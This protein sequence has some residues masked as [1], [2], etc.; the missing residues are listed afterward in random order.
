MFPEYFESP[1]SERYTDMPVKSDYTGARCI[2]YIPI[3]Q[4][5][6]VGEI[7]DISSEIHVTND[8]LRA[9]G[10]ALALTTTVLL[11]DTANHDNIGVSLIKASGSFNVGVEAHHGLVSRRAPVRW[12]QEMVD[13][14]ATLGTPTLKF[15]IWASSTAWQS[16]DRC[17]ITQNR[18]HLRMLR[19]VPPAP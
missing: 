4:L 7:W 18:G 6:V 5:P 10:K 19:Y 3:A 15:L 2:M 14:A 1:V 13:I 12:T 9:R 8:D 16:G 17:D 11:G